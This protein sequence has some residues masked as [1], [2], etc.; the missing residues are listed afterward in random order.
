[1]GS[2]PCN[3]AMYNKVIQSVETRAANLLTGNQ[4]IILVLE[5]LARHAAPSPIL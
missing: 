5:G 1:M 2:Q 3:A 4:I